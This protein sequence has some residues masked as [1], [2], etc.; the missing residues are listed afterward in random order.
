MIRIKIIPMGNIRRI[1]GWNT[2]EIE[3]DEGNLKDILKYIKIDD[4]S[5]LF[6][7]LIDKDEIKKEYSV[8]INGKT[9]SSKDLNKE[10]KGND[11]IFIMDILPIIAGGINE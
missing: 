9:I 8:L 4:R 11:N 6:D 1:V 3:V 7:L 10:L 2:K 5:S